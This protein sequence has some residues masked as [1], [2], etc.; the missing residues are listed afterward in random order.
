MIFREMLSWEAQLL[1]L[2]LQMLPCALPSDA[3]GRGACPCSVQSDVPCGHHQDMPLHVCLA[4]LSHRAVLRGGGSSSIGPSSS[5]VEKG[6]ASV[7][8]QVHGV[9][10]MAGL[11]LRG[12][13]VPGR[14]PDPEAVAQRKALVQALR[15]SADDE[16]SRAPEQNAIDELLRQRAATSLPPTMNLND[17]DSQQGASDSDD[18]EDD[19]EEGSSIAEEQN[20]FV[21]TPS[22]VD[23][24]YDEEYEE[25]RE[26]AIA[27][28]DQ[29]PPV[30]VYHTAYWTAAGL[31][32]EDT[33][34]ITELACRR[35]AAVK[36]LTLV[37]PWQVDPMQ[38]TQFTRFTSTKAQILTQKLV[39]R[40]SNT[41]QGSVATFSWF[42][43][44]EPAGGRAVGARGECRLGWRE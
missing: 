1:F 42:V 22:A 9:E 13:Y 24:V 44:C 16:L 17:T 5:G 32:S 36:N 43:Q 7:P 39:Q 33:S 30:K 12:G 31:V 41:P 4:F 27:K 3:G 34:N 19:A 21:R 38:G 20:I 18:A 29:P 37:P 11:R 10:Y 14:M 28:G 26:E 23:P 40:A 25:M 2:V 8:W 35:A 6:A 15:E